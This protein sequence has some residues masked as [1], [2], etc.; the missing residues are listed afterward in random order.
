MKRSSKA[1]SQRGRRAA[2]ARKA[3]EYA[4][5]RRAAT[6]AAEYVVEARPLERLAR[7]ERVAGIAFAIGDLAAA[8]V[9]RAAGPCGGERCGQQQ[10]QCGQSEEAKP[11]FPP[12]V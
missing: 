6:A 8:R 2:R 3:G 12:P 11:H 1:A 10:G 5:P 9:A 4:K 7:L